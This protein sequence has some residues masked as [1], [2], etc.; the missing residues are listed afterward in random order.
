M[1]IC[2][3]CG[4][5]GRDAVS[6]STH[7]CFQCGGTGTMWETDPQPVGGGG[8]SITLSG[9]GACFVA[10]GAILLGW[11]MAPDA[12]AA[13]GAWL[14]PGLF[15]GIGALG[16]IRGLH[17]SAGA[18][19]PRLLSVRKPQWLWRLLWFFRPRLWMLAWVVVIGLML[20]FSTPHLRIVYTY[21]AQSAE[22]TYFGLNGWV[23]VHSYA[24]KCALWVW[25]PLKATRR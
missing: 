7:T 21:R 1:T 8:G 24:T 11:R 20:T 18:A 2:D 12:G 9:Q 15:I 25:L 19:L 5:S 3:Y 22:C 17:T 14:I 4:G 23:E 10:A 6:P 13:G 16:L